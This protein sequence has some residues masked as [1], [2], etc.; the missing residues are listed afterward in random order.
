MEKVEIRIKG[1]ECASCE[2]LLER[3][4]KE[5]PGV[6]EAHLNHA[7]G[8]ATLL[9]S[10]IPSNEEL[11]NA[12]K[13]TKYRIITGEEKE[14][15]NLERSTTSIKIKKDHLEIGGVFIIILALYLILKQFNI[16]PNIGIS[17][18]MGYGL[19]FLIG[20]VAAFSTCIAVTGGLLAAIS[21]KY[22]ENNPN[23]TK[24][25]KIKP[26][27]Y[28]NIGR[29]LSYTILGGALGA[30]G[31][32][33]KL[34]TT[35]TGI[36]TIGASIVMVLL[37]LQLLKIFPWLDHF[38]I[39]M[40]KFIGHKIHDATSNTKSKAAPFS[41]GASTFFLPCGFTQ[42]LQIYV[43]SKG[44]F[45]VGALTM[46]VFSLGTLPALISVGA[47]SS[48]SKGTFRRYF[49]KVTAV[50][51]IILGI[52][53]I[54]NGLTLTSMTINLNPGSILPNAVAKDVSQDSN[55]NIVD[56][57]QVV[58]MKVD[59]LSYSPNTFKVVVG[60]PV[61][62]NVDG[63]NAGGCAQVIS[64]PSLGITE[65]LPKD[66]I[67]TITFTPKEFGKIRFSCTM[68]MAGPGVFNVEANTKGIKAVEGIKVVEA[69]EVETNNNV[70]KN[71]YNGPV[72][73][74]SMEVSKERGFYPNTFTIKKNVPVELE[75]DTKVPLRGCMS[76]MLIPEYNI[77]HSLTT[78]GKSILKFT[79]TK[80]EN[81]PFTCSMGS[82]LG[83]FNVVS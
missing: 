74:L 33:F 81:L 11:Q 28:F 56:G 24:S 7:S 47:L 4:F 48:F 52:V 58:N 62:F 42:A 8:R 66:E 77:A 9:G 40:P 55:V 54:G 32:V 3:K 69:A 80:E 51:V 45:I 43:L 46:L 83:Y 68:G 31:S 21:T 12:I 50:L 19:I 22:N 38:K 27:I 16:L 73:K 41:L 57:K 44:S 75:I 20:L 17:N 61:E 1:M 34:S 67:K 49:V 78:I 53:S 10:R 5:I 63:R 2:I 60:I 65:Y 13:D 72:Q 26:H 35:L 82:R 25:Q 6:N 30:L 23:L 59:G 64:F 18:N 36:I 39:K 15:K 29:V 37:G 76:V 14:S 70:Q 79:P 71:D